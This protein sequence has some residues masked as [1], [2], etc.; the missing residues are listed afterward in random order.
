MTLPLIYKSTI[1]GGTL[2]PLYPSIIYNLLIFEL[3][4]LQLTTVPTRDLY[5]TGITIVPT[6]GLYHTGM[7]CHASLIVTG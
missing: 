3:P 7:M 1:I 2:S 5:H 6:R 4:Y